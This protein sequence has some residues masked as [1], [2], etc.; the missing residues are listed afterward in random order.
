VKIEHE[1]EQAAQWRSI[2][3]D[4]GEADQSHRRIRPSLRKVFGNAAVTT[5][6]RKP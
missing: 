1:A 6:F 3:D 4:W 5:T 2:R